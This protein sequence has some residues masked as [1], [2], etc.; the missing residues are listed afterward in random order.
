MLA[1]SRREE[2]HVPM[3]MNR[4]NFALIPRPLPVGGTTERCDVRIV[5]GVWTV[6]LI[7]L[8]KG[9]SSAGQ[10]NSVEW[11]SVGW[12]LSGAPRACLGFPSLLLSLRRTGGGVQVRDPSLEIALGSEP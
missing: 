8:P 7:S 6:F 4:I 3:V 12:D 11:R 1:T 5:S 10:V 9:V 2:V